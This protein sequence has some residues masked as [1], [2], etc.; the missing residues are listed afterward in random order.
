MA[1]LA[2]CSTAPR[3][4]AP[5]PANEPVP[6][7]ALA[8][9]LS[10]IP[11]RWIGDDAIAIAPGVGKRKL[12]S[13]GNFVQRSARKIPRVRLAV[14]DDEAAW[15]LDRDGQSDDPEVLSHKRALYVKNTAGPEP[16]EHY[17]TFGRSGE[18][19]YERDFRTYP[20]TE[21][22]EHDE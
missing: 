4:T 5:P 20:L 9:D 13:F 12:A 1:I 2:G 22:D 17:A 6:Q 15:K 19:L 11:F 10:P 21:L 7:L 16:V 14:W 18:I 3:V 8:A